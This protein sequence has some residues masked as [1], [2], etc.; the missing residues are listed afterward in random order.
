MKEIAVCKSCHAGLSFDKTRVVG[1]VSKI[2]IYC[3]NCSN[4]KQFY[5]SEST[6]AENE[7]GKQNKYYDLNLRLVYGLR[8]VGKGYTASKII[9]GIMNL[10]P[11]PT[12][13]A[14]H[15][16]VLGSA[17]Q[18][19]SKLSMH[20]A[21]E[22]TVAI[23]NGKR[24]LSV[25]FDGSWQ[26][27]GHTSLNGIVSAISL[28]SGKVLDVSVL[29]K[30]CKCPKRYDNLHLESCKANYMGTSGGMELSGVEEIFQRSI[31]E[32]NVRYI[33]YL[34]DGD[35][36]AFDSINKIQPYGPD[37]DLKKLECIGHVQKRMGR[38]L[39]EL[40]KKEKS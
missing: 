7:S 16:F 25:A 2:N 38:R 24:D 1:L 26:K 36:K 29:S 5:N 3:S 21:V 31:P 40:K 30:Y 12:M 23:Q 8:S 11:P 15:E 20:K 18:N 28:K 37:I 32:Y 4:E 19:L 27:R 17:L 39:R 10:P 9:C 13:Y 33:E 22:E 34:G 6:I 35:S 14:E